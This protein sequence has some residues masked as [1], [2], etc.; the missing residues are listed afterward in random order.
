MLSSLLTQTASR[1]AIPLV[2]VTAE[3]F[4]AWEKR[5]SAATR[6]GLKLRG[7]KPTAGSFELISDEAGALAAV[8]V[9][10]SEP[11]GLWD[12]ASLPKALPKGL[13]CFEGKL[14]AENEE[15]LALGWLL[16]S[17]QFLR[18]KKGEE[19]T[20]K[21]CLSK[22]SNMKNV[23]VLAEAIAASRDLIT[24]PAEDFGPAEMGKAVREVARMF[25]AKVT[26][27]IGDDLLKKNYPAI[28]AVGRA[29]SRAPRLIDLRWGNPAHPKVTLVGKGI[30]FDTGGLDIK[31]RGGMDL[32]RKDKSG[33]GAALGVARCVMAMKLPVRLRL[34]IPAAENSVAGNAFRPS[35]IITMRNGLRVEV[36]NTDAE[37]RLVLADALAEAVTENPEILIDFAS[38]T[39]AQRS[40]MGTEIA[41]LFATDDALAN[42]L[43]QAGQAQEDFVCRLPLFQS[44]NRMLET[45]FADLTSAPSSGYGQTI[46]AALFLQRFVPKSQRWAHFDFMGWNLPGKPGRPEGG[47]PMTLRA[48]VSM[49]QKRF[50]KR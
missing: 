23:T 49:L 27:I 39:G 12:L 10:V 31:T 19:R 26:E 34:L 9:G 5:Q 41:A 15:K 20:A 8:V 29:H 21:L 6:N 24:M 3:G 11:V 7:F 43:L 17:Y 1:R 40:E 14:S 45:P 44:Y 48:V 37:G 36:G 47:E 28:H 33:A 16:G 30:V 38:L 32:M 25:G 42:D 2:L 50:S 46:T 4:K 18:Y 22:K 35:D 13:Y